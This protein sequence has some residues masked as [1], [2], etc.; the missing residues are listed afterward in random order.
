MKIGDNVRISKYKN[1]F[2]NVYTLNWSEE[3]FVIKEV[4]NTETWTYIFSDVNGG[5]IFG[6]YYEN[7][8]EKTNR[9]DF[10]IEKVI[11][12]KGDKLYV[13]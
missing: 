12:S 4:K 10:R 6:T 11:K 2:A 3:V 7:K 5:K 1:A 13:S 8:R 9:K